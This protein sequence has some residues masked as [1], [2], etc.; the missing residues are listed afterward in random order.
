ML[1]S[2]NLSLISACVLLAGCGSKTSHNDASSASTLAAAPVEP[3][4]V[5]FS[6]GPLARWERMPVDPTG[7]TPSPVVL[8]TL[9]P[10]AAKVR[11][12]ETPI[13]H[14][15]E[16]FEFIRRD[17]PLASWMADVIRSSASDALGRPVDIGFINAGGV[18]NTLPKGDLSYVS[19]LEVM[20]FDNEIAVIE[21]EGWQVDWLA[22]RF[23]GTRGGFP[24]SGAEIFADENTDLVRIVVG[25]RDIE[26][27]QKYLVATSDFLLAGGDMFG[28]KGDI[29]APIATGV[30]IRDA[31]VENSKALEA[32]GL[33]VSPPLDG[34]RYCY[35]GNRV[36]Y[37]P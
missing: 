9:A 35:D 26:P 28:I 25:G 10:M 3:K 29:A 2:S 33:P 18:R 30:K 22:A 36:E 20:P 4:V 11:E 6:D 37:L 16:E 34:W 32:K 17:G 31:L 5:E 13:A 23:A 24:I 7:L 27:R 8:E 19:F 15:E 1:S 12:Y 14:T 21:L